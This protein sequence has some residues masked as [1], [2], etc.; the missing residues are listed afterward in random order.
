ME[1]FPMKKLAALACVVSLFSLDAWA[2]NGWGLHGA[3]WDAGDADSSG[4]I[5][6]RMSIEM[7]EG[8]QL[9]LRGT[10]FDSF[11]T[12]GGTD[13][14]VYPLEGGLA[15]FLP[16][17]GKVEAYG[18][19][20]LG[21]Y[22][23]DAS[24]PADA[25]DELGYYLNAG[26]QVPVRKN[27]KSYGGTQASLYGEVLYRFLQVDDARTSGGS[28]ADADLDGVGFNLGLLIQW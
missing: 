9:E 1:G 26:F 3:Y 20:G 7:I 25:G 6:L 2:D 28:L 11:S 24:G 16:V 22:L 27:E 21:Y 23:V 14:D 19:G 10:Y 8:V 17:G 15:L 18:G 12:D 5:G 4:G 13:L